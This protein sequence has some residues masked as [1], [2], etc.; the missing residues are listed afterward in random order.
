M[1]QF[2]VRIIYWWFSYVKLLNDNHSNICH[3]N[4][5]LWATLQPHTYY[6]H[7]YRV[8][9]HNDGFLNFQNVFNWDPVLPQIY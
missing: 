7:K 5:N 2:H 6:A 9:S 4:E 8:I 3:G 1:V